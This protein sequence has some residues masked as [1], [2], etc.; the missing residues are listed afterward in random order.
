MITNLEL[1]V[2][3]GKLLENPEMYRRFVGKLNS[4][5]MTHLDIAH[6]IIIV[7]QFMSSPRIAHW[8]A[9]KQ[10]LCHLKR[11]PGCDTLYKNQWHSNVECFTSAD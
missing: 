1:T 3:E 10:I 5:T 9:F 6:P 4:L 2:N 7:S 8:T 11:A